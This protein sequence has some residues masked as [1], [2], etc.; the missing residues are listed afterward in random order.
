LDT[1]KRRNAFKKMTTDSTVP[2]ELT[3]ASLASWLESLTVLPQFQA[4]NQLNIA[5]KQLKQADVQTADLFPVLINLTPLTLLFSNSLSMAITQESTASSR[6]LKLGKLS[7][8]LPRQLA[9]LF[10]QLIDTNQL[11]D[12]DLQTAIFYALQLIGYSMRCYSLFYETP[13]DTLWKKSAELYKL[14]FSVHALNTTQV[15]KL[16]EFKQQTSINLV[17]KRNLLF[18]ILNPALHSTTEINQ[19]FQL[20]N[21]QSHLLE[22]TTANDTSEFGFY[23]DLE[24]DRP[25]C[26]VKKPN[27][28]LPSGFLAINTQPLSHELQLGTLATTL[29]PSSQNKLALA[30]SGYRQVFNSITPGLPSRT[31]MITGFTASCH[32]LQELDKLS[33]INM[34]SDQHP[35]SDSLKRNFSL[36][37]LE[38][39]RNV[40]ETSD[41]TTHNKPLAGKFV[42]LHKTPN[43]QYS[44]A[45]SRGLDCLTM[46]MALLYKEQ[47]PVSLAIIRQQALNDLNN[48]NQILLEHIPGNCSIYSLGANKKHA[49][50]IVIAEEN[51]NREVFLAP[52]KY[53]LNSNIALL[54]DKSLQLTACLE[55]N[56]F[57]ARFRFNFV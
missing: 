40:F 4:A 36:V 44:V 53:A 50:A 12:N 1:N 24:N 6:T 13:S 21:H 31:K 57:Y 34:L 54:I 28:S 9:L 32:Y 35:N 38:H 22:T 23:W 2:F 51:E 43:K 17:I 55:S 37:P 8:Q 26:P 15:T 56:S 19:F 49:F 3:Q 39:Q 16:S 45:E 10:C 11:T 33:K 5:L 25:P 30:L 18:S 46:D 42:N 47:H 14:A 48:T 20:A 29:S 52:G 7:M 27:R 41:Q